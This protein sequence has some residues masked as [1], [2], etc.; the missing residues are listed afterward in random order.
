[1]TVH[2]RQPAINAVVANRQLLMVYAQLMQDGRVNIVNRGVVSPAL[3]FKSPLIAF[4]VGAGLDAAPT[5]PVREYKGVVV[6]AGF[7]LGTG[8]AT[9]L[10]G[11]KN[12]GVVQH[13]SLFEV[14]DQGG[15][16]MGHAKG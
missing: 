3:W 15:C 9:K 4:A 14:L 13:A 16:T 10:R 11:P 6:P 1:M 5:H 12:Q 8:H 7:P 2:I